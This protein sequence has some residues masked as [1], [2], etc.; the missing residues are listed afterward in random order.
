MAFG[1][2]VLMRGPHYW[3]W[4]TEDREVA[5]APVRSL[6]HRGRIARIPILRSV[7]T[8]AEMVVLMVSV[9]RRNGARRGARF[10][11]FLL[12]A[13]A[14]D[15]GLGF[16]LVYL[17]PNELAGNIVSGVLIFI[18]GILAMRLG[19]GRAV[20]RYHGAEHKAVNAYEGGAD[21]EDLEQVA[22]YSRVHDRCGTNL[23][24]IALLMSLVSY[25]VLQYLPLVLGGVYSLL[26][27]AV[28]LE[29]FRLIGRKP[30]SRASRA[31]LAGGRA[32]QRSITTA[33]PGPEHLKLACDALRCVL[34]LEAGI[35]Q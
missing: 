11:A 13:L 15:M 34:D 14:L 12:G 6:L 24:V 9:H 19:L 33:E 25:L 10:A 23:A 28:A 27:I 26:V 2:G 18:L 5:H 7:I 16:L 32:L 31:F 4:A 22:R 17:I 30:T 29:F 20:W 35:R 21:L 1:N 8:L 3:A